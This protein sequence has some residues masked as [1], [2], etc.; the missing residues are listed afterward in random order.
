[1]SKTAAQRAREFNNN[2][3]LRGE[4]T[5][6]RLFCLLD[7]RQTTWTA[8]GIFSADD[9]DHRLAKLTHKTLYKNMYEEKSSVDYDALSAPEIVALTEAIYEEMPR[10]GSN[11]PLRGWKGSLYEGGIRVPTIANWP[12][13]VRP[14]EMDAPAHI[15]DWMPTLCQRGGHRAEADLHLDGR[16]IWPLI[17]QEAEEAPRTLY[18]RT[19]SA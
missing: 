3:S 5:G 1:M 15:V 2:P 4:A 18:W 9:L 11:L 13:M 6:A 14:G 16:D 19:P 10:L 8:N 17:A 7:E 12:G